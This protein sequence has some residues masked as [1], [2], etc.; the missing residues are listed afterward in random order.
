MQKAC[1]ASLKRSEIPRVIRRGYTYVF[2]SSLRK[3]GIISRKGLVTP[4]HLPRWWGGTSVLFRLTGPAEWLMGR[5]WKKNFHPS[6][7]PLSTHVLP[8]V[9][10]SLSLSPFLRPLLGSRILPHVCPRTHMVIE[11]TAKSKNAEGRI[12]GFIVGY[13][14]Q[15]ALDKF[16]IP[17][18]I[19][20]SIL[21]FLFLSTPCGRS[22]P[23]FSSRRWW[24]ATRK[25][26]D[27]F[28]LSLT[29][30]L[31]RRYLRKKRASRIRGASNGAPKAPFSNYPAAKHALG[32]AKRIMCNRAYINYRA[33][34]KLLPVI[35]WYISA[36]S[37]WYED[38]GNA[39]DIV[40]WTTLLLIHF[41]CINFGALFRALCERAFVTEPKT[42]DEKKHERHSCLI[43]KK[44]C[45]NLMK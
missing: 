12:D 21:P 18:T 3:A 19:Q 44:P 39:K 20:E 37:C 15:G 2:L 13:H 41:I 1:A 17:L 26:K 5:H 14:L 43:K 42:K 32:N 28:D 8:S 16:W 4:I 36:R 33:A 9:F 35:F 24:I 45:I 31:Y 40:A 11:E 7:I 29:D 34:S 22:P 10:L 23:T 30:H 27:V 25:W 6:F 38:L